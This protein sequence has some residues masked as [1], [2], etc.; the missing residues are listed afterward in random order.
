[1]PEARLLKVAEVTARTGL[2]R[3]TIW[4]LERTNPFPRRRELSAARVAWP[5]T[6]IDSWIASRAIREAL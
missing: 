3:S 4:R 5:S 2:S 1:M 6:D